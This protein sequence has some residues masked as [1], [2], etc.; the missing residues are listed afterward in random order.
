[1]LVALLPFPAA[2]LAPLPAPGEPA[3]AAEAKPGF[4]SKW[5][6]RWLTSLAHRGFSG[7][8]C[9][10]ST[11]KCTVSATHSLKPFLKDS[12]SCGHCQLLPDLLFGSS[13]DIADSG[14][15]VS[16]WP[17]KREKICQMT[18]S[19]YCTWR[20]NIKKISINAYASRNVQKNQ[21]NVKWLN[22]QTT[23]CNLTEKC[24]KWQTSCYLQ[25]LLTT[26]STSVSAA[27][28]FIRTRGQQL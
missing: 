18:E 16:V 26:M 1:M 10:F 23:H 21:I 20:F 11:K 19:F 4:C 2:P 7:G 27:A 6:L 12:A 28:A 5:R 24:L 25:K 15:P 9:S 22:L 17:E 14:P 8:I 3:A 13:A